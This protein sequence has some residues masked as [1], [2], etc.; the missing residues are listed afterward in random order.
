METGFLEASSEDATAPLHRPAAYTFFP[1]TLG[2][3]EKAALNLDDETLW[4]KNKKL[5]QTPE[6]LP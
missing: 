4:W 3:Q 2:A 6:W 1:V 5:T